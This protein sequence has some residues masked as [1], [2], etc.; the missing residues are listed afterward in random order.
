MQA[1]TV[2]AEVVAGEAARMV[3]ERKYPT[4]GELDA[5]AFYSEH[6]QLLTKYLA[7]CHKMMVSDLE[8][9]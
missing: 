7:R 8:L 2:V 9:P 3:I 1:R 5:A 6:V 4:A